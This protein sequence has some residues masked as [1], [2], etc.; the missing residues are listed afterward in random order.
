[1]PDPGAPN[2]PLQSTP[3][4]L[5]TQARRLDVA[6]HQKQALWVRFLAVT[7]AQHKGLWTSAKNTP[8]SIMSDVVDAIAQVRDQR[9]EIYRL[10]YEPLREVHGPSALARVDRALLTYLRETSPTPLD[11]R[12]RPRFL[13]MPDLPS[14]PYMDPEEQP[15]AGQL[16]ES[17]AE[18][19]VEALDLIAQDWP[20][21]DFVRVKS[22]DNIGRYL[23]G[24]EPAWEA[25]FFYRH[26]IRYDDNHARCPLTSKTLE[27]LHL[28]RIPGHAPEACFSVLKP[29]TKI[30]PHF[31]VTN[32]RAVMHLPLIVPPGCALN[33]IGVGEHHWREGEL[34]MFDDTFEHEAW[35]NADSP[36]VIL[37]MDCWH[38]DLTPV[39]QQAISRLIETI[40]ALHLSARAAA[41]T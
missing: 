2:T 22:G 11:A 34:V 25:Y 5:L 21:E 28:C 24:T 41:A 39:E 19:R 26:G 10:S 23:G 8:E 31:G 17:F 15:W 4:A 9:R 27:S 3:E 36:R 6:G 16:R 13:Y 35:N 33:I 40:A 12:Q 29:G 1:M 18:M 30:L 37:L 7:G 20:L 32:T 38:P 14:R